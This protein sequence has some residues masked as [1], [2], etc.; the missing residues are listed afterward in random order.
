MTMTGNRFKLGLFFLGGVMALVIL[1]VWL[2]G[3]FR[4]DDNTTYVSYF[5]WSV[6]GLNE[7]SGVLY[8]GVP[9]GR[10][11]R[12]RIA[13]DGRMVEVLMEIRSDFPVDSSITA[14]LQLVGITGLQVIN[15]SVDST[16]ERYDRDYGFQV[17]YPVIPV[18][19]GPI[20]TL[21]GILYR[22]T[23]TFDNMDLASMGTRM[24]RLLDNLNLLFED[25]VVDSVVS[26][27][28][29]NTERLD[30][31]LAT[32]TEL[33][34]DI[35]MMIR[36]LE[37]TAPG[38]AGNL[39]SLVIELNA[40]SKPIGRLSGRLDEFVVEGSRMAEELSGLLIM[41]R[42]HFS[43]LLVGTSGEGAWR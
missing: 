24:N 25:G 32:Y 14:T 13:P 40:L 9:V 3:G 43:E 37:E 26:S 36:R 20:Q 16:V 11:S 12:I 29:R 17:E 18:S 7:G 19:A 5:Q 4:E 34:R 38:L 42:N 31:L 6:Q 8:N 41:L 23:K 28:L 1:L 33:G 21:S 22:F 27:I 2:G 15:L 39:D 10:V 35:D 30:S